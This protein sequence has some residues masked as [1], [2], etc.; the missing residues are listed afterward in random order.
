[1]SD[2]GI[3]DYKMQQLK[4]LMMENEQLKSYFQQHQKDKLLMKKKG[5]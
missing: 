4:Q 1:M 3:K 2:A 5:Q